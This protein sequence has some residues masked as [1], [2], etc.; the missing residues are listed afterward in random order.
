[1]IVLE[2]IKPKLP[3][4]DVHSFEP[5]WFEWEGLLFEQGYEF[6]LF[7]GLNR[8]YYRREEPS[9]RAPLSYPANITDGFKLVNGHFF[10]TAAVA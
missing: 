10:T 5:T 4:C 8:Y 7:D 2:A 3:G 1:M 9:L 6:G